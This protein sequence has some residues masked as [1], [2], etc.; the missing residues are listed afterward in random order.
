MRKSRTWFK[1]SIYYLRASSCIRCTC[2]CPSNAM[3][4]TTSYTNELTGILNSTWSDIYLTKLV[5]VHSDGSRTYK[6]KGNPTF[7][8]CHCTTEDKSIKVRILF[9][10]RFFVGVYVL[11]S[12]TTT[13]LAPGLAVHI[14][15][16]SWV[17]VLHIL[18]RWSTHFMLQASIQLKPGIHQYICY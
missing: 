8:F 14:S 16:I 5:I 2:S 17:C 3:T 7:N 9:N 10:S 13:D 11:R 1:T 15:L 4:C 6:K 18:S 12:S